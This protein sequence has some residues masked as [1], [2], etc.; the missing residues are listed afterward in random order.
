MIP[1]RALVTYRS[2]V[3]QTTNRATAGAH[4]AIGGSRLHA[5]E[6][7]VHPVMALTAAIADVVPA[8]IGT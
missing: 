3:R 5:G 4:M 6:P 8:A 7:M 2:T 1:W